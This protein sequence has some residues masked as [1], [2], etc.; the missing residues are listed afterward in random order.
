V[1]AWDDSGDD[2]DGLR[3]DYRRRLRARRPAGNVT[4]ASGF[5]VG[6]ADLAIDVTGWWR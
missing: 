2:G 4:V 3:L 6:T 1:F 5:A